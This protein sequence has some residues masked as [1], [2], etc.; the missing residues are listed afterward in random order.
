MVD[1]FCGAGGLGL[2]FQQEGFDLALSVDNTKAAIETHNSNFSNKAIK[3]DLTEYSSINFPDVAGVIGGPPC[4]DFTRDNSNRGGE[5]TNLIFTFLDVVEE[6]SPEFFVMENVVGILDFRDTISKFKQTARG[7]GY[8]ICLIEMDAV[9]YG[10]PQDRTRVFTIGANSLPLLSQPKQ[11]PTQTVADAILD[12]PSLEAGETDESILNHTAPDHTKTV[13]EKIRST[14]V[15]ES[16][17]ESWGSKTRLNPKQP[18][19]TLKAGKR[20]TFH[21]AHP[22]D[23][24]GLTVR[25]RARLQTFPDS[26][27]FCGPITEQRRLTGNAVPVN[28]AR[29]VAQVV[30]NV[31]EE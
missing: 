10:V 7:M 17:Y 22:V 30:K 9:R 28:L 2:G 21:H 3:S 5:R 13:V 19:P 23:D 24:R 16:I 25:E 12:L 6:L 20:S 18:A 26:F 27:R 8:N 11:L 14:D 4:Q 1:L 15:G 31:L 29:A